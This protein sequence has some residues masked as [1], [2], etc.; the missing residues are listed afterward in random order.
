MTKE[1]SYKRGYITQEVF[2]CRT[3]YFQKY[4]IPLEKQTT[5]TWHEACKPVRCDLLASTT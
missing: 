5:K 1:C 4:G 2:A 3:C